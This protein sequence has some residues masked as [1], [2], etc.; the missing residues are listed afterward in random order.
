MAEQTVRQSERRF[1]S[2][3]ENGS[4]II[5]I[6]GGDGRIRYNSPSVRRVLGFEPEE[7]AG[8]PLLRRIH[9]QDREAV[10]TKFEEVL[11]NPGAAIALEC[12]H[13]NESGEWRFLEAS[14]MNLLGDSAVAGIVVNIRDITD[15]KTAE[16]HMLASLREKEVLLKE[17]HHRVK[18]NLQVIT[19]LLNL[20]SRGIKD[21]DS[22]EM[23]KDSQARVKSMALIHE[24]LYR[25]DD[26]ARIDFADYVRSLVNY[27]TQSFRDGVTRVDIVHNVDNIHLSVDMAVPCGLIINEL[28]S[29]SLKH[30]FGERS[31]GT[32]VI[33]FH[34][35]NDSEMLLLVSDNGR[36]LPPD[37]NF[38][39]TE[40]LGLR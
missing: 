14:A 26:L 24:K 21:E 25:S 15:R 35:H 2:L 3:I 11:A 39:Q 23:F 13:L 5:T 37:L 34:S 4:D 9:E 7:L 22:R 17:I 31:A 40:S 10:S 28:V 20:Q 1:R 38:R 33:E 30:A 32:I 27:L 29:N 8:E 12:R 18:N 16:E 19:S 36:G 6:I